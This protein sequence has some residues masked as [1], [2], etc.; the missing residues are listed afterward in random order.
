MF[1]QPDTFRKCELWRDRQV[2][3]GVFSDVYDGAVW[4]EFLIYNGTPFLSA[5]YNYAFQLNEIR[6][7]QSNDLCPTSTFTV[8]VHVLVR[9]LVRFDENFV[10][11]SSMLPWRKGKSLK[12]LTLNWAG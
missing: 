9:V 4:K 6:A 12:L 2:H 10:S 1:K 7:R 5:P 3:P 11:S 8:L